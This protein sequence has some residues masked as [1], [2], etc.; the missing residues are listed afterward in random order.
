[1]SERNACAQNVTLSTFFSQYPREPN[2]IIQSKEIYQRRGFHGTNI[3]KNNRFFGLSYATDRIIR[4]ETLIEKDIWR[5]L[6]IVFDLER[7]N[8]LPSNEEPNNQKCGG[9]VSITYLYQAV[10]VF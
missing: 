4:N 2:T 3:N 1:M 10:P 6:S 5:F 8:Q 9:G 7:T